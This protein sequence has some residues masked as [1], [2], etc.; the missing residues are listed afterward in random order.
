MPLFSGSGAVKIMDLYEDEPNDDY[1]SYAMR[2][3]MQPHGGQLMM[4]TQVTTKVPPGFD[5]KTSWFAF[6][7]AIDDWCD[8]TELEAEKWGPALRNRLEGEASV[9]KRLLDREQLR[10]PNGRGVEYFKRTLR[11]HF[12]KGAQTVFLYRFM[13][14]MKNNRGNAELMKWMTRFQIDGRR[15]EESWMDLCPELDLTSPAI[16]AEVTARRNAHNNAQAALHAA[17]NNHV[18]VPW[19]DDMIQAVHNEAI[20]LHRQQHRDLFPLSPNLIALIFISTA[21]LSQDQRQSLT[22]I[23]TH[24]NR[25]MDQY[26]VGELRET[27]IEMFCTVKTAVD[28]PMMN[29]S[30]SGGRRAF[31]VIEEG[32]LDGSFGYWAEDEEDGAEGFLDALEDVFWIWDDNDYSW[33][34]RRFQGRR[35]RKGKGK[36]RKGKG[37]GGRRFF[38]PRNKGKGKGKRKGK[39]HLVEDDS[40]YANEEWQGYENEN[41]NE[42]YWAYEDETA[43]QSQG[44]DEWQEYDEYGYFQG[45]GKKGKKGK[46]KG[47]KGHGPSEQGKG[48]GDGKG[49]ANYVNPSHSSQPSV[50]QAALPSSASASGFFVTHS[51]VSLTSVKVTQD[52][53][54]SMEPDLSGCAF[55]GQEANPVQKVEEEGVAF[56]TENQMPPTVAILDLGCTRAMDSRNAVNAFCDYVDNNDCGLWYKIEP[57]SSRFFF[58][59]SQQTKCTEKL[60]IHMYD[61]SWS[62]HT[63][64]FDIVE[65]GNVPLL[66]SLPQMRNLGFQ[67][68][69][70]PQKSFLNCTRQGIWKHQLR[71]AKSTHLV[72]DFQDIAWYMS[73]VYFKAPE[74]T[75][76]FSQHEHFEYSQLSVE[77][78]AYA[79]DDDWEFD[80]HRRELIRHHKT[81]RSQ[82]FKISGSK[83]PISFDDLESTRTTFLEMKNGTKKMEKDDW[84]AVSGP[85]KRLDKQWKGRTVFKIKAGAALPAEELSHVKSSSK[86]ARI[87]D[88]SD[89][90]KPEHSSPEEKAG[91]SKSSSAPAEEGKSGSSSSGLKRRLGRKTASPSEHD[92]FGKEFIGELEKEL[93]MELDKSDDVRKRRPKGDDVEYS[94][95]SDDERWEKAKNKPGNESLEPRRISVPLPGS[96]AQALT[97]AYRKMIKRLDDKV[98]LYK[99]HVKHYHMSPTQFRRRTS[100]LNLPERIYEKYEDVFNKCRV[101]SMS[102]APPPRA[103][104]SGIRASVFGDVVFV[105]HCEIEL[106]KK[107]YAVL[108]VLDGATNLL[109]ATAQ[110]SL[111]KKE[112]L[113][114]LRSWNEQNNCIPKAIVGDE[115]FF[116]DEFLEYYKF[117]GIKD[118]PCG[119]RTPWPNRAETA[120]RLFKKQWTIMATSLEGDERFNGVTIRQAVKMTAWARNTQLTISG[121]SPLEI[122]TGRRPPDLFDVET[123]NPEQLT[124]EPPEEDVSTLALQRLALRAHQEARQA[125]DLRHDMARRTMPSDG[126]Y[127]QGDEVFYWH[128]D[129]SKFKEKGKWIRGKVLSQEGAMVHLHTNKAVIRVNQSRVRRDHDEWHDVSIPNLDETKEE[130]KDEGDLKRE[131]HNLLCEGCLGEQAFWFYD[132]QKCDVLE[133]FGSSSGYSW[134]MA[135]K[136]V[137]VGQPIDHKHGSNLNTAYGQ[138]EAWK[139][140]MK[141]DPEIIY[142]NNPSPQSARKMVFRFCFDVITWQCKRNKKFIVTCPEGSYFSLFLDQKRWHKIL[143]KHLCWERVDLQ[144]FCKCEDEIRDMIVYHSYDDYQDDI[145]WFEFLTKKKFFS[146]EACWKDPHWKALPARFLAG[147]IRATPEVSR[148]YVADKRQEFLLEDILE[149]FDQGLLCGT[150]MHHDRY[151]KHSLLLRDLDVRNDDIPVPLRHILPQKFSTPSLVSTLRMIEALPLGTE[152]SVRES[153]NEKIVALIPGLQNIRRMT[154]PQMY[155][156]SCSIFCGTY[157]RVNPLFSLPEDSVILLWNPGSYHRI[158]FM[159]MSQLYPHYKEFQVNKWNIIAFSTET[160]GAIRRTTVGPPVNNEVVPPH[161]PVGADGND[162]IHPDDHGPPPED[163]VNMP[164][165]GANDSGEQDDSDFDMDDPHVNPPPGGQPPFPPNPPPSMPPS[166]PEVQFP[167]AQPS[168][169]SNPDETIE[170][171]MQPV[172]DD[173]SSEEP[174]I[175]EPERIEIKQ[176]QVSHDSD[177]KP[178]KA[179]ARVMTKKQKVQLPGHQNPIEVPTVKPPNDDEDDVPNPT[180]A[181]S[182]DPTIPLPTTTPHSFT[183]AQPEDEEEYNTPQSSQDTIPYQDVET[184]EP[185]ITEDEVEHLHSH[186]SDDT[187]PYDSEF[188]QFEGDYFVNLGHNSAAPDFKS[189]DINGFRQFCQYLAKNGKKTPKAESVITPQVLQKYAKQIK[190]AK[191]EEFRSFLDFTAMKFRDRRK[192][193]I[194]NFVTGRWVLTIKTDKDGQFKKFKARWVCRGFQDAQKWDLQTDSPTATRYGFRVASQHAAS[195]YWDLLHIDLKTAF[196]QGETYDLERRV[197]HLQLPSDIGLPPYLVGLCTRSVYGLADAPRRWWNRLDKFLISL[198]IQPTRA[199]RCTYVCYDGAFKNDDVSSGTKNPKQVSYYVDSPSGEMT[200]DESFDIAN[201][202]RQSFAV[203]ERLFSLCHAEGKSLYQ[204]QRYTQKKSE[205]CAWTPVVDEELLKFLESVEHKAGWIPYQNGH[206]QVSYRAKALRTPDPYYTSKQYFFRTSI[207]KRKGVWWLLEMNADIRKEKNFISLEEEAEV[208]VSIFLPAERAYLASTPQL[209]PEVVEELLEHFMDPVHGSN[210]KGRKTIGMCCLHV[211]DLFVTGTPEFLEKFKNKVKA[212]FKIGHEDVNDLMFTGQR[213]KWQLDEKTKKKSHIVVEQ[214]LCVSELTEIVIQKGQKDDEKCDKDMHTAY[215]SLLGSINWLQSRTQFQACYQFSRCASAAAS[216]TV[217]D[218]KALN[219]LCK[220][221]VNDPMELKYWPLEGNPRLMAMPD[222]AFRNNSDKSSQRAMV[223]FMSEPRKEKSRNSRGS[224][225]FFESTKIKRTTLSTTVAELYALM[226]CY[227]TCQMLRGLIKDITGHSCEL[228]MRTDANNLVTTASTTHVPEQQETIH[229]IQMLRKEACSGSIA[230]LSHIRTQWC[231]ADCLTKKSANP[232]ALIDAVK[233]GIL[234]EVDAHPPFRTL[235]EHKAYL[236]SWLPTVCHHVNFALDVFYLGESFQ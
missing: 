65:E 172:P 97:P 20:G 198:G 13:R 232:Q 106:K 54:Q 213:V 36:G 141:M 79:T 133:L 78:F 68:E 211:D 127:K 164:P 7:D 43:W 144:H 234:K 128:Q 92:D 28:N 183:P 73:A 15:L 135:R 69:L 194:E 116:S 94:P 81:L 80:Y 220:Q 83:C 17:D 76:F 189:Y 99:L 197:I 10:E 58:A 158:F 63:T 26:R 174:H 175:T 160:S 107:K 236:R 89:E 2:Q 212:S 171:V 50:Q 23:M 55:L 177:E 38:R 104:I 218:C 47:K 147:L 125:A 117:H 32:D 25:T 45:K 170:A 148:S 72:M 210:S 235:V 154:L 88:P 165:D 231:L 93:D 21:D 98:E 30:G 11:P 18:I 140:I 90:V 101:C 185:I 75:S 57:T 137:K 217:G 16:V 35:T 190:Q 67:F 146:H 199:D 193:K 77:T 202:V 96:E 33:F 163:D 85:E 126:P 142:I 110:N 156:E 132:D 223:I 145:S 100:M 201:E 169:F 14:F 112:T 87:S 203:E 29:P 102:V 134:M 230:D 59:N 226:K 109:W 5:G 9:Y 124:S 121:Y 115:A 95:S 143:S 53:D 12:V 180:A 49:E 51:G 130:I 187:Q 227:G 60:V 66:M 225:I 61:K 62:V 41:W 64:E 215:R 229:M 22:S 208:L 216:P 207:V 233:Q 191:L 178:P 24:R 37:K 44:W 157:G 200:R 204:Q 205:D 196:L 74:V 105:D 192:H 123:A 168:P 91:K 195:S 111:D 152:V 155:F 167:T 184:E 86:P 118:L 182:N 188:V 103:K 149:D 136:G 39:S 206:A 34:Q 176:R 150:C 4:T 131:D 71:M 129:S 42:G 222:A 122:A 84:R 31:L 173:S 6:E 119:P 228:H 161:P 166:T 162:P 181:S 219:K 70:S 138:A 224:L 1:E 114:H 153:T 139:K 56:H 108:L 151:D 8:I 113:T 179:K 186:G 27:F 19:T 3:R 48:Q 46:G 52:E 209:T 82:L 159:F 214:S 40:Y 120:V 221:I